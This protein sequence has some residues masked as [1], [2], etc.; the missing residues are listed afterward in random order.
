VGTCGHTV[1]GWAVQGTWNP[2]GAAPARAGMDRTSR[3]TGRG[4]APVGKPASKPVPATGP[5]ADR[6][7]MTSAA[8]PIA[9][10]RAGR[11]V[12]PDSVTPSCP[13]R[14]RRVP[15]CRLCRAASGPPHHGAAALPR[16]RR[17]GFA[18]HVGA[19]RL[20]RDAATRYSA[21][22]LA[23][24]PGLRL[25]L[26]PNGFYTVADKLFRL[27][28]EKTGLHFANPGNVRW[29]GWALAAEL[30]SR[31]ALGRLPK[32]PLYRNRS[33]GNK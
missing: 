5:G 24:F 20:L 12:A 1:P 19:S 2:S 28:A 11:P 17:R 29:R 21:F 15:C 7:P 16:N 8:Q 18:H 4:T 6:K 13:C 23:D 25:T 27:K 10:G 30:R 31:P 22:R 33:V 26:Y 9:G 3:R 32:F 14:W